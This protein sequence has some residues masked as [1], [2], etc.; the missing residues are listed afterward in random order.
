MA[1]F[2]VLLFHSNHIIALSLM[3]LFLFKGIAS[4]FPVLSFSLFKINKIECLADAETEN[5]GKERNEKTG[6][7]EFIADHRTIFQTLTDLPGI[8]VRQTKSKQADYRQ[9]TFFPVPTP[10]PNI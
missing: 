10:P 2:R 7:K 5:T 8:S 9:N 3:I 6:E 4:A 1:Y